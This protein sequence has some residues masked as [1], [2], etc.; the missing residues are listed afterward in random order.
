MKAEKEDMWSNTWSNQQRWKCDAEIPKKPTNWTH[1]NLLGMGTIGFSLYFSFII[2]DNIY[3]TFV[4]HP[5]HSSLTFN[6]SLSCP[7]FSFC[8]FVFSSKFSTS[9]LGDRG[10]EVSVIIL[11]FKKE[12]SFGQ[13]MHQVLFTISKFVWLVFS[14]SWLQY[15]RERERHL[16]QYL[17]GLRYVTF[18]SFI[19]TTYF[20]TYIFLMGK[21]NINN[22][23]QQ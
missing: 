2:Q 13:L 15:D 1:V 16:P 5:P 11:N 18:F 9:L 20:F 8:L 23:T 12:S 22:N 14:P 19:F 7:P 17:S 3:C 21:T 10:H 6:I 4:G